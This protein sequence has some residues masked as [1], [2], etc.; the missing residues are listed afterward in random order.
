MKASL[1]ANLTVFA[2]WAK[3]SIRIYSSGYIC[4]IAISQD[5]KGLTYKYQ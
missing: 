1:M 4:A 3:V 2:K 5:D